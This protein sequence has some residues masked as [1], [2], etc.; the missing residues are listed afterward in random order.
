MLRIENLN[1]LDWEAVSLEVGAGEVVSIQGESGSGKSLLLRAIADLIPHGGEAFL[2]G[3]ACSEFS[4]TKWRGKVSFLS[5]EALWWED[6]VRAHFLNDPELKV[7]QRLGLKEEC[8]D[9]EVTRLSM[10]ERQR[11]GLLRMLDREPSALLLDE[12]TANLD[13]RTSAAVEGML[14]DYV[15]ERAAC[16]IWVTHDRAQAA[17]VGQRA[18]TM[19]S[20]QL[21][22]VAG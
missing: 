6:E 16:C 15:R 22:K 2:G 7:L 19:V 11:L 14:L 1:F 4:P 9:W 21:R 17:R 18:Y 3:E 20:K 12:P 8:L 13:D 5:A 10:G